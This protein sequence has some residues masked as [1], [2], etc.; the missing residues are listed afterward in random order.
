MTWDLY[1]T[2]WET[3][4]SFIS[5]NFHLGCKQPTKV[6]QL[7]W[8]CPKIYML[9]ARLWTCHT[10]NCL[11]GTQIFN[12]KNTTKDYTKDDTM[13]AIP[14]RFR[15]RRSQSGDGRLN[16][17]GIQGSDLSNGFATFQ[18]TQKGKMSSFCLMC[19]ARIPWNAYI[20]LCSLF[21]SSPEYIFCWWTSTVFVDCL[22]KTTRV[23]LLF[24]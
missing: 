24:V 16:S 20:F 22:F 2:H 13:E 8:E 9:S 1:L 14:S 17:S 3:R 5:G 23:D 7:Y 21:V 19:F 4:T 10:W 18:K 15:R 12:L 6:T 11:I